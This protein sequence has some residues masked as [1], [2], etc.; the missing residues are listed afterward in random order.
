MVSRPTRPRGAALR[1]AQSPGGSRASSALSLLATPISTVA[2]ERGGPG[3]AATARG[4]AAV[5]FPF[6]RAP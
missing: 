5:A 2:D 4:A 6:P 1:S 3:A